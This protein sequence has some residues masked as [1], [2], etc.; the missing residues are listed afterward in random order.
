LE[1][2]VNLNTASPPVWAGELA[3]G[4]LFSAGRTR[5]RAELGPL[6]DDLLDHLLA[7]NHPRLGVNWHLSEPDFLADSASRLPRVIRRALEGSNVM[8]AFDRPR[9]LWPLAM[10]LDRSHPA[11]LLTVG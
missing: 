3:E 11:A 6:A 1:A 7:E 4:P 5:S 2:V 8:F 10:V 9:S